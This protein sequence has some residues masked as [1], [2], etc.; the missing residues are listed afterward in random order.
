MEGSVGLCEEEDGSCRVS[1]CVVERVSISCAVF[2]LPCITRRMRLLR[3]GVVQPS[4][5]VSSFEA[6][7]SGSL[8]RI[9]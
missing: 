4:Q 9:G 2:F 5:L 7:V 1:T 6:G 8:H 3:L